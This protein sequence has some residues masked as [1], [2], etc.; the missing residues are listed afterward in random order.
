MTKYDVIIERLAKL[1]HI[2]WQHWTKYFLENL[3][4]VNIRR[5]KRQIKTPYEKL[6]EKEKQ[7]DREWAKKAWNL[8]QGCAICGKRW[9]EETSGEFFIKDATV[10]YDCLMELER[11][12]SR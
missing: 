1:E 5:W 7:S 10:C 6:S 4:D 11:R 8:L 12:Q 3:I 9:G 2:Q